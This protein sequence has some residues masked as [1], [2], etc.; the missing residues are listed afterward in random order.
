MRDRHRLIERLAEAAHGPRDPAVAQSV[1]NLALLYYVQGKYDLVEPL[2]RRAIAIH[3]EAYGPEDPEVATNLSNLALLYVAQSRHDEAE[4]LYLR[5]IA[6]DEKALGPDDPNLATDLE[7]LATVYDDQGCYDEAESLYVRALAIWEKALGPE[8]PEVGTGLNN[9][10]QLYGTQ[11]RYAEAEP[12]H[13]RALAIGEKAL[14][15]EHPDVATSLNNLAELYRLQGR[16]A[17]VEPLYERALAI[18]RKALGKD[19]PLTAQSMN[20]LALAYQSLGRG[21]DAEPLFERALAI[22]EKALGSEHPDV[23]TDLNNLA[24]LYQVQGRYAEAERLHERALAIFEKAFG[25]D[26]PRVALSLSGV[27]LAYG[28][29]GRRE[30]AE[31][32]YRRSLA[33]RE[34]THGPEHPDMA[35]S[36]TDIARLV[37]AQGRHDEALGLI[38]RATAIYRDRAARS[39]GQRT[40]GAVSEQLGR[41]PAFVFHVD[42]L[43]QLARGPTLNR[44]QRFALFAESFEVGQLAQATAAARAVSRMAVRFAAEDDA[45]A[46]LVRARQD[47]IERLQSLDAVLIEDVAKP[48]EERRPKVEARLVA[49]VAAL[50]NRLDDLDAR[51]ASEFPDYAELAAPQPLAL[52]EAQRLLA[53]D[54][55]LVAYLVDE[56]ATYLW[57]VR[58]DRAEMIRIEFGRDALDDAVAELRGALYLTGMVSFEDVPA[59][60]TSL[61]YEL[62]QKI[63]QPAERLLG[64]ARHVMIVADGGLQSLPLGVLVAA[65]PAGAV[66]DFAGYRQ[67]PWLAKR[68]ALTVLPS[69]GSLR[70]LRRFARV[71]TATDPF[72]GF[73]DPALEGDRGDRRG[74]SISA[75]FSKGPV[76]DVER[77]RRFPPLPE[78]A[79]E[80]F[81][82]A[83]ALGASGGSIHLRESATEARVKSM[84]L[85]NARV[86]AFATHALVAGELEGV[87]EPALVLTPPEVGT[88]ADD[89]LLTAS[90]IAQLELDADWV[91][92]SACNTAAGDKPG[93]EGLS[94][95]AKAF[96]YAGSRALLVSHWPVV[97][98]AATRLTTRMFA[99]A[100]ADPAIGRAEALRRSML[101]MINAEDAPQFA[102][103][104]FWAP[105][106]V[107]GEGGR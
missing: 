74:I 47:A 73:G 102:H 61:A 42:L 35:V 27:A 68:Y 62:Y 65:V 40:G 23:A 14:G 16:H 51:L 50:Q 95:L 33:I 98:D 5:A 19:H 104:L 67:V 97:S 20:N 29:R 18:R 66:T 88:P 21:G 37:D 15:P 99:E 106:S 4:S 7:N 32:L 43:A 57:V 49:E 11:G 77:I 56:V 83:E 71:S 59:F 90:E 82:I 26:H 63:F 107:V 12:L 85:S 103:P 34:Q 89:G 54:E 94:G 78:T 58:A 69:V 76:A 86:I 92:L 31:R 9:L 93:A 101:A 36:L 55:A 22:D 39:G 75:A 44:S 45:L 60:D 38:R 105:F 3:E 53:V 79:D 46:R 28:R 1:N 30:E 13:R 84:D 96:F 48:P 80:L 17:E 100:E 91:I 10:A 81:A 72:A 64:G 24:V 8:H 70:A 6:I 52:G 25:P 2:F 41:R 87:A